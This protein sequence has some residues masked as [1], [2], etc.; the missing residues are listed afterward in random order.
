MK[1]KEYVVCF[2]LVLGAA[3]GCSGGKPSGEN[4]EVVDVTRDHYPEKNLTLQDFMDVEYVALE[5]NDEFV[6][7]GGL[8]RT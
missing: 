8:C 5:T 6:N 7:E 1:T 4:Q 3:A 2:A